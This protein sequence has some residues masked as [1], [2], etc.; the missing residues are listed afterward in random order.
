[1]DKF[2]LNVISPHRDDVALSLTKTLHH[3]IQL[4]VHVNIISCFT[5]TNWAPFLSTQLTIDEISLIR[6]KEDILY[7]DLLG[8]SVA[9]FNLTAS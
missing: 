6:E 2:I 8:G 3:L 1:M 7:R 4:N 9:L 5:I